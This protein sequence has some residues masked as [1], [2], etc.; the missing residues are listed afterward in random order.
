M[1]M[2][3]NICGTYNPV[4]I[5]K[6]YDKIPHG[7]TRIATMKSAIEE[8]DRNK[9]IKFMIYFREDLCDESC[10][11]GDETEMMVIFPEILN[12]IDRYPDAPSTQFDTAYKNALEHVLWVYKWVVGRCSAFY[13]IPMEDCKKFFEDFKRR[14]ISY[15]FNLKPYYRLLYGFYYFDDTKS[16]E[17]FYK[18]EKLP[19]DSNSNC[20]A[21]DRN[22]EINFYLDKG[23]FKKAVE[24]S[25]DIES[26]KLKCGNDNSAWIRMKINFMSYY[27]DNGNFGEADKIAHLLEHN[28]NDKT[29][30]QAWDDILRCYSYTRPG[31]ALRVYK[32]HWKMWQEGTSPADEF[33]KILNVCCFWKKY[34]LETGKSTVKLALDQTFPLHNEEN[35]YNTEDLYNYYYKRTEDIAIKFDKRNGVDSYIKEMHKKLDIIPD[36]VIVSASGSKKHKEDLDELQSRR[37]KKPL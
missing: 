22:T 9:D 8:A 31:R 3:E 1:D 4:E 10:F 13:Q 37:I 2:K 21:C 17:A 23:D 26:F 29:E 20:K 34:R 33:G 16:E 28:M 24:L 15:G 12:L 27:M 11:Y 30:S 7:K 32:K 19:R 18:F 25:E 35:I 36:A 6:L 14:S 5:K